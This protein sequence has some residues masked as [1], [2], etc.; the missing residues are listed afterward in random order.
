MP[1]DITI[2]FK[3]KRDYNKFIRNLRNN[4]GTVIHPKHL[5][6]GEGF[7]DTLKNIANSSVAKDVVRAAGP[8]VTN[9][10]SNGV[11]QVTGSQT[12]GK[13]V[14]D[15][16]QAGLNAYTNSPSGNGFAG[17]MNRVFGM[18]M[19]KRPPKGSPQMKAYMA[20]LR[21]MRKGGGSIMPL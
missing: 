16:G 2:S 21:A 3:D 7:F 9:L 8:A 18:G 12:A 15:L 20:R 14:G 19:G 4:K 5:H 17:D 13:I 6:M 11:A 1:F 10:L